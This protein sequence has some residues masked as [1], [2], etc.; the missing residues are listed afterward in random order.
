MKGNEFK[1]R[2]SASKV[3]ANVFWDTERILLVEFLTRGATVNSERSVQILNNEFKG[4]GQTR[5]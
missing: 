2:T 4:F 1:L 5:I 3:L